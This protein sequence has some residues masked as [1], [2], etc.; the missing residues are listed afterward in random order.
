[1]KIAILSMQDVYN[2][3]SLLQAYGLKKTISQVMPDAEICYLPIEPNASDNSIAE[4]AVSH[5]EEDKRN[6]DKFFFY[7]FVNKLSNKKQNIKFQEFQRKNFIECESSTKVDVC[8]IGSDEVFNCCNA[9][10]WGFT[11]QLFGNVK[12]ANRIITYAASCGFATI[13]TINCEMQK[14]IKEAFTRVSAF[15]VRDIGTEKFVKALT[16]TPVEFH[17]DPVL[18]TD[19]EQEINAVKDTIKIPDNLCVIYSYHNRIHDTAE[20]AEIKKF[21]KAHGL[22]LVTIGASQ[23]WI[24]DMLVLNPFEVLF[25]FSKAKFIITDTFHGTIFASKYNGKFATL[26]R[27]SNNNKLSDLVKRLS[28]EDHVI[29]D[30]SELENTYKK[31]SSKERVNEIIE[32]ERRRTINYLKENLV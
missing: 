31:A 16:T 3:G 13:D 10:T 26:L 21:A 7:R 22:R 12:N 1:M 28:I 19:F 8:V 14:R 2:F 32:N 24:S 15:S 27:K 18:I 25:V 23:K 29:S 5:C 17:L 9:D 20:I 6:F 11:T 4:K 30:F